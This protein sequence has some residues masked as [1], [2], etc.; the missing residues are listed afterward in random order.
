MDGNFIQQALRELV[1]FQQ[2]LSL[3]WWDMLWLVCLV[4]LGIFAAKAAVKILRFLLVV[5]MIV[6]A[7]GFLFT[8]GLLPMS[9][10]GG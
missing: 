7:A 4:V 6:M 2:Q 1:G 9:W 5:G 3:T 8:S 10:L